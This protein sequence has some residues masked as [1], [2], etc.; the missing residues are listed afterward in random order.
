MSICEINKVRERLIEHAITLEITDEAQD[1][2]ADKGYD[3]EYGARPL[4]RL[5]QN[6]IED[7]LSDGILSGKFHIAGIV[8]ATVRD[9]ELT[10]ENVE[11]TETD[12]ELEAPSV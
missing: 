11:E 7:N 8:R 2:L 1:W 10:L 3:P 9:G 5:I 6:E 4:R 12:E